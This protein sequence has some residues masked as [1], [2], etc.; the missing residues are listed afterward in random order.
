MIFNLTSNA[1]VLLVSTFMWNVGRTLPHAILVIFLLS[2]GISLLDIALIQTLHQVTKVVVELPSGIISDMIPR[3]RL[4]VLS[5]FVLICAFILIGF[6]S[7]NF[8]VLA[9]AYCL[10]GVGVSLR[11][12]TLESDVI[13]EYKEKNL[14]IRHYV[15]AE[16][17]VFGVSG[18]IGGG[19]GG[20]MYAYIGEHIYIVSSLLFVASIVSSM[21][22]VPNTIIERDSNL[23]YEVGVLNEILA[24]FRVMFTSHTYVLLLILTCLS[25]IFRQSFYQYWQVLY[26]DAGVDVTYFGI[27]YIIFQCCDILGTLIYRYVRLSACAVVAI[28]FAMAL[29]Y[30]VAFVFGECL[31][32]IF[33]VAI[34]LF[35]VYKQHL[36]V[37]IKKLAPTWGTSTYLSTIET[38]KGVISICTLFVL[39]TAIDFYGVRVS[40]MLVFFMFSL[41][42]IVTYLMFR[43]GH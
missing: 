43:R 20:I 7:D 10:Y 8:I 32:V 2:R 15:V 3:K 4:Y 11:S 42:S 40:Y 19:V 17:Y 13:C 30:V 22:F 14:D 41:L 21:F 6:F 5:V 9:I 28:L 37:T 39:S 36:D 12:G 35:Y 29:L 33:P 31:V 1:R 27:V 24:M 26:K 18:I 38:I 16:S 34:V 25:I 23:R